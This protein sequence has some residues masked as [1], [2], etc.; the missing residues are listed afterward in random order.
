MSYQSA[1]LFGGGYIAVE[2]ASIWRGMGS[3][4]NLCFRRELP[5]RDF[6]DEMRALLVKTDD[7]IKVTTDHGEELM[8]DVVLFATCHGRVPNSKRLNFQGV[9]VEVD[10][11]RAVK[12][13]ICELPFH[14]I[15]SEVVG[16]VGGT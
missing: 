13:G 1:L 3:T 9:G 15:S 4:V 16:G 14:P 7:G 2:F 10:R 12:V 5:L 6:D 8:A 11:T